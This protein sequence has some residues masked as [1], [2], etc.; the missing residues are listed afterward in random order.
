MPVEVQPADVAFD[1]VLLHADSLQSLS[2]DRVRQTISA[3]GLACIRG[4]FDP[5]EIREVLA[6][7]RAAFDPADDRKHDPRDSDAVRRNFQKLQIGANSG[8]DSRRTLGRFMRALYNP[9]FADDIHGMRAHFITLARFRNLLYGL[10]PEFAVHG[11][12]DGYWSCTRLQQYPRGGGFMVPH[13]DVYAQIATT[14]AGL[15]Y[16]QPMLL[17][18]QP[19][20][21]FID[22][23]AYVDRG[24]ERFHYERYC[25]AGD[26]IAYDGHSVHGVADID[27]LQPLD[28]ATFSGR[29]VALVSLFRHLD[30]NAD[31]Y[32]RMSRRAVEGIGTGEGPAGA[33]APRRSPA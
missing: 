10:P 2:I 5:R 19:G 8:I 9:I 24:D 23:G 7:I 31:D 25:R 20:E 17:L 27:P 12:Q 11:T 13:R 28:L 30:G 29:T 3:H 18:S 15:G 6:R 26:L 4:L 32:A 21:D 33:G 16:Y 22:G 1:A 14:E